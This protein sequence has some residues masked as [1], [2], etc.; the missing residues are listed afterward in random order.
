MRKEL[1]LRYDS[2]DSGSKKPKRGYGGSC[3]TLADSA[4]GGSLDSDGSIFVFKYG[5]NLASV[6]V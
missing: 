1:R 2:G 6:A 5:R 4:Y 3:C